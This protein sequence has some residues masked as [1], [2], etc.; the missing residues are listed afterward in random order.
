MSITKY[1]HYQY[2]VQCLQ[3]RDPGRFRQSPI[4]GLAAS[5]SRDFGIT[6]IRQKMY[7]LSVKLHT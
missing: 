5:Q 2:G 3:S 4:A 1:L 6:K 7:F